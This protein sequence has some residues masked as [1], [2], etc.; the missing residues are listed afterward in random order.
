MEGEEREKDVYLAQNN[1]PLTCMHTTL[2]AYMHIYYLYVHLSFKGER[3]ETERESA[4]T[5][6]RVR[7]CELLHYFFS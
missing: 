4:S 7:F 5:R 2:H 6:G 3:K 1:S